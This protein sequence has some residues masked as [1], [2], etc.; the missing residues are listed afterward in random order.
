AIEKP[1][2]KSSGVRASSDQVAASHLEAQCLDANYIRQLGEKPRSGARG[3][4]CGGEAAPRW[5]RG[6]RRW[7]P[8][9]EQSRFKQ[10]LNLGPFRQYLHDVNL[11]AQVLTQ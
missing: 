5:D 8:Q 2:S 7:P 3:W 9:K 1:T 6:R 4:R 11:R 10:R